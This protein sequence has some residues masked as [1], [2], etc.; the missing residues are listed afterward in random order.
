MDKKTVTSV[1]GKTSQCIAFVLLNN[2]W[3]T[4]HRLTLK[5]KEGKALLYCGFS[6]TQYTNV[7]FKAVKAKRLKL[8]FF[9]LSLNRKYQKFRQTIKFPQKLLPIKTMCST[10]IFFFT[11]SF[12]RL[13]NSSQ[14][15][16]ALPSKIKVVKFVYYQH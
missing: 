14:T 3:R 2:I 13:P 16:T 8:R 7:N 5:V 6:T 4:K 1:I 11:Y 9:V 12:L 10:S 15:V